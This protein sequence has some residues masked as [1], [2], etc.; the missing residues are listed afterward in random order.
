MSGSHLEFR[1]A[2]REMRAT[3]TSLMRQS[4]EQ[5]DLLRG[6][7]EQQEEQRREWQ[8]ERDLLEKWRQADAAG[9]VE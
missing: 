2:D 3:L 7:K 4:V 6:M 1:F 8:K 5:Q 9:R